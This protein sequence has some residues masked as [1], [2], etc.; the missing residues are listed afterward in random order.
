LIVDA[1]RSGDDPPAQDFRQRLSLLLEILVERV[2]VH[3]IAHIAAHVGALLEKHDQRL[4]RHDG[5]LPQ[6]NLV[7]QREDG[8]VRADAERQRH[9]CDACKEWVAA[10]PAKRQV[11][12]GHTRTHWSLG[13]DG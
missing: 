5:Q 6:Q 12:V 13:R 4:G 10:E 9:N 2:G 11:Q 3:P 7:D 8:R 1:D